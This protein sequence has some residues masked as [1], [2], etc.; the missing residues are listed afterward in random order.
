MKLKKLI[1]GLLG[2]AMLT[3]G[4]A[5]CGGGGDK[6]AAKPAGNVENRLR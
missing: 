6:D 5:G 1:A 2:A 4:L 3:V